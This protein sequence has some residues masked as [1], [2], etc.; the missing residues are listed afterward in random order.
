LHIQ[1]ILLV[2]DLD[3]T[4]IGKDFIVPERNVAAVKRFKDK[5]GNFAI[6]TGRAI[7]SGARYYS[8]AAPNAPCVLLNGSIIYDFNE[9]KVL[10]EYPLPLTAAGFLQKIIDRFPAC[11]AEV[12]TQ[13]DIFILK[14][15]KYTEAHMAHEGLPCEEC[16]ITDVHEK[17]D[18]TLFA[19]D[20]DVKREMLEFTTTFAH[21][22][23]RFVSSSDYYFEMLPTNVDK[24]TGLTELIRLTGFARE[25][26]YAIGD[27]YNDCEMLQ[28]AGFAAVPQNAPDD[29]KA[30]ADL[31]VGHC[32]DGA[33]ADLI[34]YIEQNVE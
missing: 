5:G 19:A 3:G 29:I 18:K 4:L 9:K 6:A 31:V 28:A 8:V 34:E 10:M 21:E 33:V 14:S 1:D 7:D 25:N 32:Y 22:G 20:V 24:G 2:T 16:K 12:Y 11:G 13:D 17:W 23:V 26:V 15:N 27:Y 30:M